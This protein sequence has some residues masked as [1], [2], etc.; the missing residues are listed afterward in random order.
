MNAVQDDIARDLLEAFFQ[1]RR[2]RWGQ[3]P[4]PGLTVGEIRVLFYLL[5]ASEAEAGSTGA[6]VSQISGMLQVTP[7]TVTQLISDLESRGYVERAMDK[8][9]RRAVRVSL[10]PKGEAAIEQAHGAFVA[11]FKGLVDYLGEE[12]SKQLADLLGKMFAYFNEVRD[13]NS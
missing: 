2:L 6:K 4:I 3:S 1:F 10:T 11:S 8:D 12:Q 7:P 13:T 5:K 9:D